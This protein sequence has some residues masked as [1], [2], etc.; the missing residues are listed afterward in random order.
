MINQSQPSFTQGQCWVVILPRDR[1]RD[2]DR[3]RSRMGLG[4]VTGWMRQSIGDDACVPSTHCETLLAHAQTY[5]N[6]HDAVLDSDANFPPALHP[7]TLLEV[8]HDRDRDRHAHSQ[9]HSRCDI[10]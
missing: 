8:H 5:C 10:C 6:M 2:R 7:F 3:D 1:D 9:G 4:P